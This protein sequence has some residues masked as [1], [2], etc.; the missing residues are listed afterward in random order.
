[1]RYIIYEVCRETGKFFVMTI[2]SYGRAAF[3]IVD[4]AYDK[5]FLVHVEKNITTTFRLSGT[6]DFLT[7]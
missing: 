4:C 7:I 2:V 5:R 6:S 3:R 1:M